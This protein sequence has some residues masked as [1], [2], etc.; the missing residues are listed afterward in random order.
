MAQF[1]IVKGQTNKGRIIGLYPATSYTVNV[2]AF[3]SA[4]LTAV[5]EDYTTKTLRNGMSVCHKEELCHN[6]RRMV[7]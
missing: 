3:N 5:S 4:G 2:Q 7:M 1:K 6:E